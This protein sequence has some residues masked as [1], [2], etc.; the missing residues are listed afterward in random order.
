MT[1]PAQIFMLFIHSIFLWKLPVSRF[2]QIGQKR[3]KLYKISFT[4][5]V[6][7]VAFSASFSTNLVYLQQHC[8]D[9]FCV[10]FHHPHPF[11]L[12]SK[13]YGGNGVKF[14]HAMK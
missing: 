2:I 7:N 6:E 4:P 3:S 5:Y 12:I 11:A 13:K 9:I 1:Y 10:E 8:V 14:N